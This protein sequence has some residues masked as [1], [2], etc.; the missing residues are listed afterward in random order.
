MRKSKIKTRRFVFKANSSATLLDTGD[1][2]LTLG[3]QKAAMDRFAEA[4][5]APDANR[6]NVRLAIAKVMAREGHDDDA[7]QQISLGFAESRI[8]EAPPI[9]ADNLIEAANLLLSMHDFDLAT[10]YYEKAKQ[11]GAADEV[12][13]IG[14][15]NTYLA[16]G[17][18]RAA[19]AELAALGTDPANN[20]NY[21]Y[22]LAQS[23]VYRQ[24]HDDVNALAVLSRADALGAQTQDAELL[25]QQVAGNE[26]YRV[27]DHL[28][29]LGNFTMGGLYDD[30][31]IYMLDQQIFG[32]SSNNPLLPPPRSELQSLATAAYRLHFNNFP[33][34]SG[35]FQ[36]RN[37]QGPYSLPNEALVIN[38]NTNDYSFNSALNPVLRVGDAS[39]SFNTGIQF[40]IR[41]DKDDPVALD[42]NLLREFAFFSS[43][44]FFSWISF[45]GSIYHEAGPFTL[46][47][48]SSNDIGEQ[49]EFTVGRPWGKTAFVTGYTRRNLTFSPLVRQFF[50]TSTYAGITRKFGEKLT[51]TALGEYIRSYRVQDTLTATAQALRPGGSIEYQPNHPWSFNGEFAYTRGEILQDYNN[52]YT[53]AYVSYG[54]PF[55]R[56]I[57]DSAGSFPV[58]YPLRFSFGME[59]EQFPNFNGVAKRVQL[60]R[61]IVRLTVF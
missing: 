2:L 60:V 47:N 9:T 10:Q 24:R 25:M 26:G 21:D 40:T 3:D 30:S 52:F 29:L 22:L 15:A 57:T 51:V 35:Y 6:V 17:K 5:G 50:T 54:R 53:A 31:T 12:V 7:R 44:S 58:E 19:D 28:S 8:G 34:V 61:P 1:A 55:R 49:I 42:Q 32:L 39:I 36:L 45:R 37:A 4:L 41:R 16:Q 59:T 13:G 56:I 18:T 23:V 14:L 20:D 48:Q 38:R 11:A 46:S 27:N 33:L 43:T